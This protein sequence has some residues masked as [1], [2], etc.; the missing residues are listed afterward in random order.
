M[1]PTFIF[2]IVKGGKIQVKIQVKLQKYF[3]PILPR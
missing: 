3:I 1:M 2:Q